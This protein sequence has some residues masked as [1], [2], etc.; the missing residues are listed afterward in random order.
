MPLVKNSVWFWILQIF[1]GTLSVFIGWCAIDYYEV[2]R[3]DYPDHIHE[4]E[5]LILL[6]PVLAFTG[7]YLTKKVIRP[8]HKIGSTI[9]ATVISIV[10]SIPLILTVGIWFH[11]AVGGSL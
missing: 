4:R 11:F 1:I 3:P 7:S 2:S 5:W 9:I 8:D 6:L 10:L